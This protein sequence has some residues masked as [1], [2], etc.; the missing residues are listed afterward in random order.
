MFGSFTEDALHRYEELVRFREKKVKGGQ[1]SEYADNLGVGDH[2]HSFLDTDGSQDADDYAEGGD[3]WDYTTCLRPDGTLYG[4]GGGKCR[5]GTE[6]SADTAR[7]R[8]EEAKTPKQKQREARRKKGERAV[9]KARA[10]KALSDLQR[11]GRKEK[12]ERE[13][14]A[15][16]RRRSKAPYTNRD[17]IGQIQ[18]LVGKATQSLDRLQARRKRVTK[19]GEFSKRLDARIAR[20]K[21]AVGKLQEAKYRLQEK[22]QAERRGAEARKPKST[23]PDVPSWATTGKQ[24]R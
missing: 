13:Q 21:G 10:E 6:V 24:L 5:K 23:L 9:T 20:L 4:I 8:R 12:A 14:K 15:E 19:E 18:A 2:D 17:R 1:G 3:T 22:E 16:A 11:E 7:R